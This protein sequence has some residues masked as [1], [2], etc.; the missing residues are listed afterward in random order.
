MQLITTLPTLGRWR[1]APSIDTLR[2]L[3]DSSAHHW[4]DN[5]ARLG[6]LQDYQQLF[7]TQAMGNCL[8]HLEQTNQ[9][10]QTA[11]ILDCG[12]GTGAFSRAL[13]D[14]VAQPVHIS[15]VDISPAMLIHA[16]Q[17]LNRHCTGL[18]LRQGDIRALP[19]AANTFDALL[20][21]HVLEY[22]DDLEAA[23][24]GL[25]RVL[26]PGCPVIASISQRGPRQAVMSMRWRHQGYR[27]HQ[28]A[29]VF[30]AVGLERV[31][32]FSYGGHWSKRMCFAAIGIKPASGD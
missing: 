16:R 23:L 11:H 15:G 27:P 1:T 8:S 13:L 18:D 12:V 21:A 26:K 17:H 30:Q 19:F 3:Y 14:N 31:V 32:T 24:Q 6:Q 4:H 28:L 5:L 7:E 9:L 10:D 2:S 29:A 22:M 20:A 25:I